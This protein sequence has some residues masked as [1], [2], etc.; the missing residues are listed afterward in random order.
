MRNG[1]A[2][3]FGLFILVGVLSKECS[4]NNRS[5]NKRV[6]SELK[7]RHISLNTNKGK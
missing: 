4:N 5:L 1:F 2:L 7:E 6:F 3:I